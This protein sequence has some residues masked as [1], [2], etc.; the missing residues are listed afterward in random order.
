MDDFGTGYSSLNMLSTLPIDIIKLDMKF[1][2]TAFE[3]EKN[4]DM[5]GIII[6]IARHISAPRSCGTSRRRI[7]SSLMKTAGPTSA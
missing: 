6:E 4:L 5:L 1:I 7:I 2:Q 3:N